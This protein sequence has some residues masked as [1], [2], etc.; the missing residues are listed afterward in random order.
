MA[1]K[2]NF[3]D[4]EC[5]ID[6]NLSD[7]TN[8]E[9]FLTDLGWKYREINFVSQV[10]GNKV[11]VIDSDNKILRRKGLPKA[12][13]IVSNVKG[14]ALA[15]VT[16]DCGPIILKDEKKSISAIIH[17]GWRGASV[18]VIKNSVNEMRNL[19]S[20]RRDIKAF[21]GPMIRQK[22]YQVSKEFYDEFMNHSQKN[23]I[24][25][26]QDGA[27]KFLFDLS[28]YIKQKL[29]D[30]N[31]TD[32]DDVNIDTYENYKKYASYRKAC[33]LNISDCK[34]NISTVMID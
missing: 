32:I 9:A 33:H 17:A 23:E 31:I 8:I 28:F 30:E 7:F 6:R 21:L 34:R 27:D 5:K 2:H 20:K 4:L 25:F 13:A 22:S 14:L 12:D 16:A 11:V 19:G 24:F 10:H 26:K 1:I 29:N 18:G 15:I 3:F